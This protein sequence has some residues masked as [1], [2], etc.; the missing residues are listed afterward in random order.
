MI[1]K[2]KGRL[3]TCSRH[4]V[5]VSSVKL[6]PWY[7]CDKFE[8]VGE[9]SFD[10]LKFGTET[11]FKNTQYSKYTDLVYPEQPDRNWDLRATVSRSFCC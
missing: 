3:H 4:S 1:R 5:V 7:R 10:C 11:D 8:K 6:N 9:G 2:V